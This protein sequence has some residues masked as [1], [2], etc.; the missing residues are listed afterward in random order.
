MNTLSSR[1]K[2][3][4]WLRLGRIS[5]LPTVWSNVLAALLIAGGAMPH[6]S[7]LLLLM[8]ALSL[9]YVGGMY[10]ND[11]YDSAIDARDRPQRPIPAGQAQSTTVFAAGFAMLGAGWLMLSQAGKAPSILYGALLAGCIVLYNV[12]HK[13]NPVSPLI[14]GSCRA[15]VY[16]C[17]GSALALHPD[18]PG[19]WLILPAAGALLLHIVGLSHAA[20]QEDQHR[21]LRN[22]P[23]AALALP[24]LYFLALWWRQS[25]AEWQILDSLFVCMLA[26]LLGALGKALRL[27]FSIRRGA[28]PRARIG[29]VVAQLIAATSLLDGVALLACQ[30]ALPPASALLAAA[31]CALA[32]MLTLFF[33]RTIPGT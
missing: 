18:A 32:W 26:L 22:W 10:L 7:L 6:P 33:Q 2:I 4:V 24:P 31:A 17:A 5:N 20:K 3:S 8:L 28:Q 14:M 16:L 21:L 11:A 1:G 23:L 19:G 25:A 9:F 30:P 29:Q 15:L 12:W 27:L 13:D